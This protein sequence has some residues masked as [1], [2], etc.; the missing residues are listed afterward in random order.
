MLDVKNALLKQLVKAVEPVYLEDL[1]NPVTNSITMPIADV[2]THLFTWYR[3]VTQA[4]L[5]ASAEKVRNMTY[6]LT[7]P[8]NNIFLAVHD[9]GELSD[10]ANNPYSDHQLLE[11]GLGIIRKHKTLNEL[12]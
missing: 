7:D 2:M 1:R 4:T 6:Y 12:N 8:I 5:D 10:A 11:F 3:E 9:L